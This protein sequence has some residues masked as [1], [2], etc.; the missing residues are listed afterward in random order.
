MSIRPPVTV[1]Y[2]EENK[3]VQLRLNRTS[4]GGEIKSSLSTAD[5]ERAGQGTV[6]VEQELPGCLNRDYCLFPTPSHAAADH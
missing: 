6:N 5:G 2:P 4:G 1:G 3:N